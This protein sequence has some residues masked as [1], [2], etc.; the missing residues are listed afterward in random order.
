MNDAPP[1]NMEKILQVSHKPFPMQDSSKRPELYNNWSKTFPEYPES[2]LE[3]VK[4][5]LCIQSHFSY[6]KYKWDFLQ[7]NLYGLI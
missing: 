2:S 7:T 4:F 3:K 1:Y 5:T 6:F